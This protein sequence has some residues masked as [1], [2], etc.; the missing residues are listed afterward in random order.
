[1]FRQTCQAAFV[2]LA[3]LG[4][5]TLAPAQEPKAAAGASRSQS[6]GRYLPERPNTSSRS[7]PPS[8]ILPEII[9]PGQKILLN[10]CA[11]DLRGWE[12][13]YLSKPS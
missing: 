11:L 5:L 8:A 10:S 1:M 4:G 2:G 13:G 3:A 7:P 9:L 6:I 12:H